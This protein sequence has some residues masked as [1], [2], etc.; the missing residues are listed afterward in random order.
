M[1]DLGIL[2][3]PAAPRQVVPLGHYTLRQVRASQCNRRCLTTLA[4]PRE[5]SGPENVSDQTTKTVPSVHRRAALLGAAVPCLCGGLCGGGGAARAAGRNPL[6]DKYF[7][8]IMRYGMDDY[9]AV[10]R[11][12]KTDLFEGLVAGL[13]SR[14]STHGGAVESTAVETRRVLEVGVG[15]GPNFPFYTAALATVTARPIASDTESSTPSPVSR[16]GSGSGSGSSSSLESLVKSPEA[17]EAAGQAGE[18][19]RTWL[20]IVGLDPNVEMLRYAAEAATE[21]GLPVT[22]GVGDAS[23]KKSRVV[24]SPGRSSGRHDGGIETAPMVEVSLVQGSAEA[25]PFGDGEFDAAVVTLVM[26]SVASPAKALAELRRV[27][28]PGGRLLLIEHV[29]AG[30]DRPRLRLVQSLLTPL[31]QLL[32]DG[33]SLNRD[34][35]AI[36]RGAG[37]RGELRSFD[38]EG[39]VVLAPHIA[40]M[41]VA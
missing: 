31:Q 21:I 41:L 1:N 6:Y 32:A 10:I 26:C 18:R 14:E 22:L 24:A 35:A 23:A 33:C 7:A 28:R 37:W 17:E 25:L 15:T 2:R 16:P 30:E 29:A 3:P 11:P 20:Q 5:K 13:L 36:V 8:S 34:T 40:G 12:V 4:L 9:E 27:V 19:Q 38:L 39:L